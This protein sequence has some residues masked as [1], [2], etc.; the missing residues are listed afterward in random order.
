VIRQRYFFVAALIAGLLAL[1][2]AP[3]KADLSINA[4]DAEFA[5]AEEPVNCSIVNYPFATI[6]SGTETQGVRGMQRKTLAGWTGIG[7]DDG[8]VD[9]EIDRD[10][11][12]FI[13]INYIDPVEKSSRSWWI[14]EFTLAFLFQPGHHNDQVFEVAIANPNGNYNEGRLRV[15]GDGTAIWEGLGA[16]Q[17]NPFAQVITRSDAVQAGGAGVFQ[18]INPFL[19]PAS[20]IYFKA[21]GEGGTGAGDSDFAIVSV[22]AVPEP[23]AIVLLGTCILAIVGGMRRRA[24]I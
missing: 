20:E 5:C 22:S 2:A 24:K 23:G 11:V 8:Y 6:T 7:V 14:S 12:E 17:V 18:V 13:K 3:A 16:N 21:A 4:A 1:T 10:G 9:G 19:A 15:T